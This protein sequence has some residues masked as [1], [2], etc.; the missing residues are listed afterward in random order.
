MTN[1]SWIPT[2][3]EYID[4]V[5]DTVIGVYKVRNTPYF[6]DKDIPAMH[7]AIGCQDAAWRKAFHVQRTKKIT[8]I[9]DDAIA[10]SSCSGD[11]CFASICRRHFEEK[12]N[13]GLVYIKKGKKQ[14]YIIGVQHT[15]VEKEK[16]K[17][18]KKDADER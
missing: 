8:R 10:S 17:G 2:T 9:V 7:D 18:E 13:G 11:D 6:Y 12:N 16:K 4:M 15:K 14:K 3:G 1:T 5:V